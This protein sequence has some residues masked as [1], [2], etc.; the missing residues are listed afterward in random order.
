MD[1]KHGVA[2]DAVGRHPPSS[3]KTDGPPLK[4]NKHGIALVPQPSDDP[5]DP[6]NWSFA[7]KHAAMFILALESLLV[8][9]SATLI[10]P[11]AHSLAA[12]FHTAASKA[13][14]IGSAPSILYAIAPFFWIPLSHRVGRRP[15]LLAS[16]VIALVA[17]IGVA[18]SGSYA[19]A[20]GCRMVMGFGG[21]AGLCIGPAAISDMFFLHE[22]GS[23]MGVNSI[24]LV[25]APY[26]GGVAGGAIQQNPTL[27]WRWSM[28]V[29]AITYAVQLTGQFCLVP[30]TIY[31][32]G[33][34]R[35]HPHS[36]ARRFGFR[37]PTNPTGES[38][39]QTFRRPYAMFVYPAVVVPSFW[40]STAVMTEV[41]NTAGFTL[42]FGITSRFHFT[43]AQV[44]Y[45]FLS[46]LIG[47]FSG[48][49]L[50]GPLCDLLVRRAL[51]KEHGWRAETLLVL[52]VTG[53]VTIVAGLL[54]YG[55]QLQGSAPGDWASPLAG[56]ILFVFGQEI[57][58]T[59]VMTY[60]TD[61]YPD[62][63]AEVAIVFQFFFNLMCFHPPFY[64]PG[65]IASAGARTPYIVYAV[66][67]LALFPLLMGPFIWKGEQIRSK[68]PLFRLSK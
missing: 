43:T 30:E 23:R 68:G 3:D 13:T 55:I 6:L 14:Y 10:A 39:L 67:P 11:G 29:S 2:V 37:T 53:L 66:I 51:K 22:K 60:M 62:Q 50:A 41:A 17:A 7:K 45:C 32:R 31:E 4:C 28:Y 65:W 25:V 54:V 21:S 35:H 34:H 49:L 16:Q 52:S 44:G 46:G 61:C 24:L 26:V 57:I 42:N 27:G 20:L 63:A 5:E 1:T 58:V 9:F 47:A 59:V 64:T 40:V 33:G 48:E 56:M 15:V 19:Q 18:R 38:W 12:Q 8:K 36:V